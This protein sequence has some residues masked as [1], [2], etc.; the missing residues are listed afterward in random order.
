MREMLRLVVRLLD[1]QMADE[2]PGLLARALCG[3]AAGLFLLAAFSLA[4]V[5]LWI[6]LLPQVGPVG[7]PLVVAALLL[8]TGLIFLLLAR[9]K[10]VLVVADPASDP[11][12][13]AASTNPLASGKSALLLALFT[14]AF[15]SGARR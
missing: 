13:A 14:A 12:A 9:R 15:Q 1:S 5:A 7:A 2:R 8:V 6:A 11:R 10:P 4:L 3:L